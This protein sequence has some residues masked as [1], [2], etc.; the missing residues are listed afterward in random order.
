MKNKTYTMNILLIILFNYLLALSSQKLNNNL[1][2]FRIPSKNKWI[3]SGY[4]DIKISE[5][6]KVRLSFDSLNEDSNINFNFNMV[7]LPEYDDR[8]IKDFEILLSLKTIEE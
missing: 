8:I 6:K 5:Q 7:S 1:L 3:E 2:N 4:M